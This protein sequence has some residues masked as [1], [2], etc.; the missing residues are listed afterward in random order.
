MTAL[1]L[2]QKYWHYNAFRPMQA[3][4]VEHVLAGK[5][6]LGIL[7]TGGGKSVCYQIPALLREG[8]CIV[9]S[10][11][12]ALMKDQVLGLKTRGIEA[13]MVYAGMSREEVQKIYE[14]AADEKFKFLFVSPERLQSAQFLDY[15]VEWK[16]G[17]IAV[18]EAHCISQWGYDFRPPYL[19]I[20]ALRE[21]KPQVPI[22]ALTASATP[23]VKKDIIE[24]L[25]FCNH[26]V[27]FTSFVRSNIA[28]VAEQVE[29]KLTRCIAILSKVEGTAIVYCRNRKRT[30]EL[31]EY[32]LS[33]GISADYYHAGLNQAQRS[34]KQDFW[35][36][37]K[38]RVIVCTNAFGMGIDKP[39]VRLVIHYDLPDTP[40]AYYQEAGR[41]GRDGLKSYAVL[42]YRTQD[43]VSLQEGIHIKYPNSTFVKTF[44]D[45]VCT[46]LRI[47]FQS[48]EGQVYPFQLTDFCQKFNYKPIEVYH[49]L[50]L[51]ELSELLSF[52]ESVFTSSK[53]SMLAT[54]E[55]LYDLEKNHPDLDEV[56]KW[57]LRM[58]GGL[59]HHYVSI[60]EFEIAQKAGIAI[61]YVQQ[62]LRR[63]E[64]LH[65]LS[66]Q[67]GGE[68]PLIQLLQVRVPVKYLILH[69]S[70]IQMLKERYE[71]RVAFM[72]AFAQESTTCRSQSIVA[73]FGE[74]GSTVC[75]I[76]DNCLAKRKLSSPDVHDVKEFLHRKIEQ[77]GKVN[78][79]QWLNSFS[80]IRREE[81]AAMLRFLLDEQQFI[82]DDEGNLEIKKHL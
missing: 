4:I 7:P 26:K 57:V 80:R 82:V 47:P 56:V 73:Y 11:L 43:L 75:G 32:F 2:L 66:Y 65:I 24:K 63:L 14:T 53:V 34:D 67:Q 29:N 77:E 25:Q 46:Y 21:Y 17:M 19:H 12:I 52:S 51:L 13:E 55:L 3:E 68:S 41:A 72:I 35:I 28:M 49:A 48:G 33:Q 61:D 30:K 18:D 74:E 42:L 79:K 22:L 23:F 58:Y 15:F 39:D 69:E 78:I 9:V 16:V 54:K 60:S 62:M 27:F 36:H 45:D 1:D 40:E 59:W 50:K 8:L 5:D 6:T 10:P 64:Q 37:N 44:Y 81:Q 76:C 38:V 31:A 71:A 20:A 70:R